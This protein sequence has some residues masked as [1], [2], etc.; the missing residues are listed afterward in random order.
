VKADPEVLASPIHWWPQDFQGLN[1]FRKAFEAIPLLRYFFNSALMATLDV[2]VT[3]IF[4]ALAGYG[5]AKF[6]FRGKRL[7]FL[8][9]LST[10]MIP[11]QV[12]VVPL[13]I[14]I[15]SMGWDD[16]YQGL[17]IPGIMNA[18]GVFMMRQF[19]Y[20]IPDD[21]LDAAR[22]DGA[23]EIRIFWRIVFPLLGPAAASLS[24][25]IFLFSWNNFLWPLIVIKSDAYTTLPVGVAAFA[26]P[27]TN[28]PA[29]GMVMAISTLATMPVAVLF[30][31]FQRYF[32]EGLILSGLKG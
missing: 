12:L 24:T 1:Q 31:F 21:L 32:I 20:A 29:W 17:I 10:I 27:P 25:I 16:T 19:A 6:N 3:V 28:E 5:F 4:S 15:H 23:S 7:L 18:F 13:F 22:I 14:E 2:I 11:F 9:V 8:F 26:Q 30:I